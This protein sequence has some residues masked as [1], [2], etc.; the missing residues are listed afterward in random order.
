VF[1]KE[2]FYYVKFIKFIEELM[3]LVNPKREDSKFFFNASWIEETINWY[4]IS[5]R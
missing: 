1:D 4:K 3:F 5:S 2:L